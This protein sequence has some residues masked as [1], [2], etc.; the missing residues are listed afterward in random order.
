MTPSLILNSRRILV[1]VSGE[2]KAVMAQ[3]AIEGKDEIS[4]LPVRM[5]SRVSGKVTWFLIPGRQSAFRLSA[6]LRG[7]SRYDS[8]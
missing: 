1:M 2:N 4:V 3:R 8:P 7:E 5:L 6:K